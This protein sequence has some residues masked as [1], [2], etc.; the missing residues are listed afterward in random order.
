MSEK[1]L[2][3]I[4]IIVCRS[5]SDFNRACDTAYQRAVGELQIDNDG[6]SPIKG[7]SRSACV[8]RVVFQTYTHT[9]GMG[10]HEHVY[11]FEAQA[12]KFS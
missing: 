9:G 10:G 12:V 7:W 2:K 11:T 6:H 4:P 1:I 8:V 3:N 5:E